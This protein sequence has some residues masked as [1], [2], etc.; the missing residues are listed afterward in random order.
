MNSKTRGWILE[1]IRLIAALI[2]G[3]TGGGNYG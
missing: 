3:F 2:A 1:I